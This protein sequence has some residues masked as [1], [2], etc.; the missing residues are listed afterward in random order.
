MSFSD[1][2]QQVV[3]Q[4]GTR[5]ITSGQAF[6]VA[7]G[8]GV[9]YTLWYFAR[10]K[11]LPVFFKFEKTN[12]E[13]QK[14]IQRLVFVCVVLIASLIGLL[15]L[16]LD[17]PL[18][19]IETIILFRIRFSALI[20]V[21]LIY[22]IARLVDKMLSSLL[23]HRY[24]ERRQQQIQEG[25]YKYQGRGG[26][27]NVGRIVRPIVYLL[28]ATFIVQEL[29]IMPDGIHLPWRPDP[30]DTVQINT[31]LS[32]ILLLLFT[33]LFIWV[34]TEIIL[35]PYYRKKKI[36]TGSQYAINKLLTYLIFVM[37]FMAMLQYL[38]VNLTVLFGGAAAL[39]VGVGLG[40]QQTFNDLISGI[41]LL[42]E[43][44][45]EIGDIVDMNGLVGT[46][47][48]IGVRTSLVETRDSVS[49]IVPNS[50]LVG[51]NVVNWSHFDPKARFKVSIG[52]AYG[53]DTE[54]VKTILM[55][56]AAKEN[57]VLRRPIPEVRFINFGDSAL[58]FEL[59]F[60]SRKLIEIEI[61]KSNLRFAIDRRFR[62]ENIAIPFPQRDVWMRKE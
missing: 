11:W 7:I 35:F 41:I 42:F 62:E 32:A 5:D 51:E 25:I 55:D 14:S 58:D 4:T 10:K 43:R 16:G 49:V 15:G 48:K 19:K 28:A 22:Y 24:Q 59:L 34:L 47:K 53:S 27:V 45:V 26:Q 33:R 3:F 23:T 54:L 29:N 2:W 46:V 44:T 21:A 8:L 6:S 13:S 50:K 18:S 37:A 61:T 1:Y 40:L 57:D 31:I 56:V 52:V 20:Q 9:L 38:E 36:N 17:F 12:A 60:W 30:K 39:L